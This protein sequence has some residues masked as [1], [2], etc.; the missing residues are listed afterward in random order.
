[1]PNRYNLDSVL[2]AMDGGLWGIDIFAESKGSTAVIWC[3]WH[4]HEYGVR[5]LVQGPHGI[6]SIGYFMDDEPRLKFGRDGFLWPNVRELLSLRL[7]GIAGDGAIPDINYAIELNIA[8][9]FGFPSDIAEI[10]RGEGSPDWFPGSPQWPVWGCTNPFEIWIFEARREAE[11][12]G[13]AYDMGEAWARQAWE[14]G[15]RQ[16]R[17]RARGARPVPPPGEPLDGKVVELFDSVV[18]GRLTP[19]LSFFEL[20]AKYTERDVKKARARLADMHPDRGGSNR[21]FAVINRAAEFLIERLEIPRVT[22]EEI[23]G[24]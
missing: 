17:A 15:E 3:D 6:W 23:N 13:G 9:S 12:A 21:V 18:R 8:I 22:E 10:L 24:N 14:G 19:I 11:A 16:E 20:G 7:I 4:P 2:R 1:M 5:D